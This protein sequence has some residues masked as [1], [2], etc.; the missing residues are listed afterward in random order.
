MIIIWF[1]NMKT[2]LEKNAKRMSSHSWSYHF[3]ETEINVQGEEIVQNDEED[4]VIDKDKP[5]VFSVSMLDEFLVSNIVPW[6]GGR[7]Y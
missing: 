2:M 1:Q 3:K 6:T 7:D 5:F 4:K